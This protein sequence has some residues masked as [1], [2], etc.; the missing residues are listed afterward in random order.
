[1]KAKPKSLKEH[2][3]ISIV[4]SPEEGKKENKLRIK[5]NSEKAKEHGIISIVQSPK[6]GKNNENE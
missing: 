6:E 2:G 3:I 4:Q 1:M 5:S